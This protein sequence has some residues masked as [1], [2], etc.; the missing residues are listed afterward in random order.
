MIKYIRKRDGSIVQFDSD[1]VVAAIRK[2]GEASNE[3]SFKQTRR[4]AAKVLSIVESLYNSET[5]GVED[6]QDIVETVLLESAFKKTAKAYILYR[7]ARSQVRNLDKGLDLI[8]TYVGEQDWRLRE[9]ASMS[10]SLQGMNNY[11]T[12]AVV[13]QYWL[14]R[15]YNSKIRKAHVNGDIHIHDLNCLSAYC[16]GWDLMDLLLTGFRG[17]H[18]DKV[19]AGPPKHFGSVLGQMFNFIYTLTG[20]AAGAQAFSNVDTLL[21]PFIH[22]DGLTYKEV[23]QEIQQLMFNLNVPTRV[24]YQQPF[25]NLAFDLTPSPVY[26]DQAVIIG[27]RPVDA[28]Y[29]DFQTEMN[30][31]NMAFAEVMYEGDYS[32]RPFSFPIPT[33][34]ITKDFDWNNDTFDLIW[35]MTGKFGTPY[36]ANFVSSDMCP[37][38][39]RSM[40]L[41]YETLVYIKCK[42][43]RER[44][45]VKIGEFLDK[46]IIS[47]YEILTSQGYRPIKR[48]IKRKVNKLI[49]IV[50]ESGKT[51][52]MSLDH[53]H[54]VYVGNNN[55][56]QI[57]FAKDLKEAYYCSIKQDLRGELKEKIV[58]VEQIEKEVTVYD[59]E[60]LNDGTSCNVHDF[61]ANDILTHNCCR[62]R[63]DNRKL[64]KRTGGLFA[65]SPLTGS[66][67]VVT[68]N[69][70]RL[71]Y[72]CQNEKE[73]WQELLK[74]ID[75]AAESLALKRKTVESLTEKGL[76]PYSKFYLRTIK[77]RTGAYWTNHFETIG[78]VGMNEACLNLLGCSIAHSDGKEFALKTLKILKNYI[79]ELNEKNGCLYNLEATPAEGVSYRL[80]K[81]DKQKYPD[82]ITSGTEV[83]FYT[84]S[85]FLPVDTTN[86]LF[87]A[88]DHQEDLQRTYTG[89][90][91]FHDFIGEEI[92]DPQLVKKL[93]KAIAE[94]YAI[95][96]FTLTPTFSICPNHGY[97]YGEQEECPVCGNE[98]E[99]FSRVVGYYRPVRRWNDGKQEEFKYRVV[100]QKFSEKS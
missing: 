71:G 79:E 11:I 87:E 75:L 53:P 25:S 58:K 56:L 29:G 2:A 24:G 46:Y 96:Y 78:I 61:Y 28:T 94:N 69:L 7:E 80:A 42:E 93:V 74:L 88:L 21:A 65:S 47:E 31:F 82:I 85:T 41:T 3:F 23:R 14:D 100:Y 98:T 30:M 89:G 27:G 52:E 92:K 84:N 91:V 13:A 32:G 66:I 9:N 26:K 5:P 6:V 55:S 60:I 77:E 76:Y 59:V 90:T 72:R 57:V 4:I 68:I 35:R 20:E 38:D 19:D 33:Y 44:R 50:T 17:L 18:S 39:T 37:E 36:F 67:G 22:Y 49:R 51:L 62:L 63:L 10:F 70:P 15:I 34:N 81:I 43:T 45:K 64:R 97:L 12:S 73:F 1:K 54:L 16:V 48:K 95:P 83:P 86:D 99:I 40:C 8:D